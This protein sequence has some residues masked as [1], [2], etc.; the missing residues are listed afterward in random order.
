VVVAMATI[1]WPSGPSSTRF[2][3]GSSRVRDAGDAVRDFSP[4]GSSPVAHPAARTRPRHRPAAHAFPRIGGARQ[5]AHQRGVPRWRGC[6]GGTERGGRTVLPLMVA[7]SR[8]RGA[9][10]YGT[11]RSLIAR[12]GHSRRHVPAA[13]RSSACSSVGS[14]PPLKLRRRNHPPRKRPCSRA[15]G[16][17]PRDIVEGSCGYTHCARSSQRA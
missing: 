8:G 9:T 1:L 6:R 3:R 2:D 10:N 15:R 13:E 4:S 12:A 17:W 11:S 16:R 7:P 5:S 14:V